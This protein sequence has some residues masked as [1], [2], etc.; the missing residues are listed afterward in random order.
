MN[1]KV[2]INSVRKASTDI[3][4]A[5]KML[6]VYSEEVNGFE[7]NSFSGTHLSALNNLLKS[8]GD[9]LFDI[10]NK[11]SSTGIKLNEILELYLNTEKQ[12]MQKSSVLTEEMAASGVANYDGNSGTYDGWGGYGGDQG[13]ME[14]EKSGVKFLFWRFFEDRDLI[15]FV[16]QYDSYSNC[17][18]EDIINLYKEI[19]SVGCGFVAVINNI[20]I[21]YEGRDEE[22]EERFGFP[23]HDSNGDY[24]FD[25]LL[26]DF[27]ITTD[28]RF[29]LDEVD[30]ANAL[31]IETARPYL[32]NP[33]E[34]ERQYGVPLY[35]DSTNQTFSEEAQQA[36]LD[37][38]TGETI[39]TCE[40][41][42]LTASMM[43]N[44][45]A[46]YLHEKGIDYTASKYYPSE[47]F[48]SDAVQSYIDNGQNVNLLTENVHLYTDDNLSDPNPY[49]VSS[50]HWMTI[51]GTT[52]DGYYIVSS[53]GK[54]YY[55]NPSEI[56]NQD[57]LHQYVV[58]DIQPHN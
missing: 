28:D 44:R 55:I 54:K 51:T 34:F 25:R 56:S 40:S 16:K 4:A 50:G 47:P 41:G 29:Y 3:E 14:N 7:L 36:V 35:K 8:N 26:I 37:A 20:I 39:A 52:P 15:N 10:S 22:F 18:D 57:A 6:K 9:A 19:N 31:F 24:N 23:L 58:T 1:L 12:L 46:G 5:A 33:V 13:H 49:Y 27:Y 2:N 21:E 43:N 11:V 17:S 30:G 53:W 48:S 32:D 38:H 45:I 42:G